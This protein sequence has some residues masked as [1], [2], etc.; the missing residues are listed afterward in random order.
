M[1]AEEELRQA[2]Q[3]HAPLLEQCRM[4]QEKFDALDS[5]VEAQRHVYFKAID[6]RNGAASALDAERRNPP[7]PGW[8]SGRAHRVDAQAEWQARIAACVAEQRAADEA[9][10]PIFAELNRLQSERRIAGQELERV[11]WEES[12]AR[13]AVE[14]FRKKLDKLKPKSAALPSWYE[15]PVPDSGTITVGRY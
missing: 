11:S 6:R 5:Q 2:E 15:N 3:K 14:E 10:A 1:I 12:Y 4:L 7:V 9:V 13:Q 8:D